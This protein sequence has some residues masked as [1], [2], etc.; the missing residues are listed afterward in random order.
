M[1]VCGSISLE[2]S[3]VNEMVWSN[4]EE[5]TNMKRPSSPTIKRLRIT[6]DGLALVLGYRKDIRLWFNPSI[7]MNSN[8]RYEP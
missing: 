2:C 6:R 8:I 7:S 1:S 4:V 5:G 3:N